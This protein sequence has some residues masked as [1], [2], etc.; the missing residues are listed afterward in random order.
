MSLV[1]AGFNLQI[2]MKVSIKD[3]SDWK[4]FSVLLKAGQRIIKKHEI[5]RR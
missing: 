5:G 1:S 3:G 2:Y 4:N